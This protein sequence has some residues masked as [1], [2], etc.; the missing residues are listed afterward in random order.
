MRTAVALL[1]LAALAPSAPA[2][3]G[4]VR[5]SLSLPG[6]VLTGTIGSHK[7]EMYLEG[8]GWEGPEG[9]SY[10]LWGYY[11]YVTPGAVARAPFDCLLIEGPVDARGRFVLEEEEYRDGDRVATGALSG[12]IVVDARAPRPTVRVEGTWSGRGRRLPF[13]LAESRE[14]ALGYTIE[15]AA[16]ADGD[17]ATQSSFS[18]SYPRMAGA[19]PHVAGFNRI[20][21]EHVQRLIAGFRDDVAIDEDDEDRERGRT[22]SSMRLSFD[23]SYASRSVVSIR[24]H[25]YYSPFW[26]LAWP[27]RSRWGITY[28]LERGREVELEDVVG[29]DAALECTP[30]ARRLA[31]GRYWAADLEESGGLVEPYSWNLRPDGVSVYYS[32]DRR[33]GGAAVLVL[34]LA[35]PVARLASAPRAA[36]PASPRPAFG[37]G[38]VL[39]GTVGDRKVEMY[40]EG[41]PKEDFGEAVYELWGYYHDDVAGAWSPHD[42]IRV[43]GRLEPDG[44]F[45]LRQTDDT[46]DRVGLL[47]GRLVADARGALPTVRIAGVASS[48][49]RNVRF[50]LAE[51]PAGERPFGLTSETLRWENGEIDY[52][53]LS[54]TK[55]DDALNGLVEARVRVLAAEYDE[56]VATWRTKDGAGQQ[57]PPLVVRFDVAFASAS[58]VSIRFHE[59]ALASGLHWP[60]RRRWG[61]TVDLGSGREMELEDALGPEGRN[62]LEPALAAVAKGKR[63]AEEVVE[64]YDAADPLSWNLRPGGVSVYYLGDNRND[65]FGELV[66]RR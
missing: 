7:V 35:N 44:S 19:G 13:S 15:A 3:A 30:T 4:D 24:F 20:V 59:H 10:S 39:V 17:D 64:Y 61:V 45:E 34:P 33:N 38:R 9:P 16:I 36:E 58:A 22:I 57:A 54:G 37:F 23:V 25:E 18:V 50:S 60:I 48:K 41:E 26:Y 63:W 2:A 31:E 6:S 28:D 52:P 8:A 40:L 29:A 56:A 21:D 49:G 47:R 5:T 42:G 43:E 12:R 46:D 51:P 65:G 62:A 53:R 14:G 55:W 1:L 11:H 66:L 32:V 27:A